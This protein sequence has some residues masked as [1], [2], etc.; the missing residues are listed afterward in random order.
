M[1]NNKGFTLIELIASMVILAMLMAI[2]IPNVVGIL[3]QNKKS[4]Y[5]EDAGKL[6]STAKY[7]IAQQKKNKD[8]VLPDANNACIVMSL[9]YLDNSEFGSAPNG[10]E[11]NKDQSYVIVQRTP[12][13]AGSVTYKYYVRLLETKKNKHTGIELTEYGK[14]EKDDFDVATLT[15]ISGITPGKN[16]ANVA[17]IASHPGIYNV[18]STCS[19]GIKYLYIRY[20]ES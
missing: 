8:F 4:A 1:K 19:A 9:G 15:Q 18:A 3:A 17:G 6:V 10:G 2:T 16:A 7:K 5:K 13:E 20:E 11:Y 14:I 12:G